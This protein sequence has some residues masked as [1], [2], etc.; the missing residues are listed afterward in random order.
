MKQCGVR[1]HRPTRVAFS[2]ALSGGLIEALRAA[3]PARA[4]VAFSPALSGGLI[5]A[6]PPSVLCH[7]RQPVFPRVKRGPH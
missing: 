5:E 2:P 1:A 6:G 4:A 3:L 7:T